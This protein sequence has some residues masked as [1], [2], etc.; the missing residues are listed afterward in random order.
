[1]RITEVILK[2]SRIGCSIIFVVQ[3]DRREK[4]RFVLIVNCINFNVM[5]LKNPRNQN[6]KGL[7]FSFSC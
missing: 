7:F 4:G 2:T 1:M 6:L 5:N 3:S